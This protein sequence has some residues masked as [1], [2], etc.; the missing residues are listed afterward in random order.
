MDK[1]QLEI[2]RQTLCP[3]A[4]DAQ[5]KYFA[6]VCARR[7]L[8]PFSGQIVMTLKAPK[9]GE[10][11]RP[12]IQTT[13]DGARSIASRNGD[14]A[15]SDEPIFDSET[16]K[17]PNWC[18]VTVYKLVNG[19]KYPFTAKVRWSEFR[20]SK[21]GN[22]LDQWDRMGYHM[23]A[24]VAEMHALRKAWPEHLAQ[25]YEED[26]HIADAKLESIPEQP[27]VYVTSVNAGQWSKARSGF[28][29][30]GISEKEMFDRVGKTNVEDVN[31]D[32]FNV[33]REW[34]KEIKKGDAHEKED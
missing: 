11:K 29:L 34:M 30:L 9:Q 15:G 8:D 22:Y 16:D 7:K 27:K 2:M 26:E 28:A 12:V 14:Y 23:L 1:D 5:L 24:K 20:P 19:I 13:I 32:D 18:K 10:P 6:T 17:N 33:L 21:Y 3:E 31:E 4:T 25:T